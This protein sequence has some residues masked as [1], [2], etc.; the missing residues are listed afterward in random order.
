MN[1]DVLLKR[2]EALLLFDEY[3]NLLTSSQQNIF[4]DY[5]LY[6]LSLSEIAE[7][8]GISRQG[9]R[10]IIK[11]GEEELLRL[12][13]TLGLCAHYADLLEVASSLSRLVD[14][15]KTNGSPKANEWISV[16]ENA[17]QTILNKGV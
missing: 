14:L 7:D 17:V 9:V 8:E 3:K 11:K 2:E 4:S 13:T 15:L 12:E 1:D 10:H 16:I 5:Y 6:D